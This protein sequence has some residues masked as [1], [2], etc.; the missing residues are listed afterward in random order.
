[1]CAAAERHDDV[2]E[3]LLRHG[4]DPNALT[5]EVL[6]C[7][8]LCC[9]VLCRAVPCCAVLCRRAVLCCAVHVCMLTAETLQGW[10]PLLAACS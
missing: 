3:E 5:E 9:A 8:V 1:M 7:A 6:C 2:A 10:T 4:A